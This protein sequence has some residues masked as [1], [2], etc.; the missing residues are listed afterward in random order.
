MVKNVIPVS[1]SEALDLLNERPFKI[2]AGGTDLMVQRRSWAQTPPKFSEDVL[3]IFNLEELKYIKEVDGYIVIGSTTPVE[4]VLK[5]KLTPNLLKAAISIMASPALRN[6]ATIAGNIGNA[7]PAGDTLPILYTLDA[8]IVLESIEG[9][10]ELPIKDVI[11]GPGKHIIKQNEIIK[12]LKLPISVFTNSAFEKVGGRK[13]DA[14][15]KVSFTGAVNIKDNKVLDF[16]I[17]FGAVSATILRR[18]DLEEKYVGLTKD[19]LIGKVDEIVADYDPFVR[20]IDDQRSNKEYRKTVALN[21]LR[22]FIETL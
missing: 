15:S 18:K 21:L 3:Y 1:Y 19:E 20:P 5:N 4:D 13:A 6:M 14:I 10:R 8:I 2:I 17:A 7:S 12:E 11:T 22:N 16:R 9:I